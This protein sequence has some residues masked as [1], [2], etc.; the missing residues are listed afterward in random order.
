MSVLVNDLVSG[1]IETGL[2]VFPEPIKNR[3]DE[4]ARGAVR[5]VIGQR[6]EAQGIARVPGVVISAGSR[7]V[8][9]AEGNIQSA[10]QAAN[11]SPGS[12]CR[13]SVFDRSARQ[14]TDQAQDMR[15]T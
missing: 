2:G 13:D 3:V 8:E 7:V 6:L 15:V 12:K 10:H 11:F 9:T 4:L 14:V 5:D 1:R